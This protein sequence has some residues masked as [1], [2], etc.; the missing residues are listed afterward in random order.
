[1]NCH[2]CGY[3]FLDTVQVP[4]SLPLSVVRDRNTKAYDDTECSEAK[5]LH[6]DGYHSKS[7]AAILDLRGMERSEIFVG[8]ASNCERT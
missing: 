5:I 7:H 6:M 8:D 3:E 1:M 4:K 2:Y